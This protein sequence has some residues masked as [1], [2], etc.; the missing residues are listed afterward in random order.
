MRHISLFTRDVLQSINFLI[1]YSFSDLTFEI[2]SKAK[3]F[4]KIQ[5]AITQAFQINHE[6][7]ALNKK[8]LKSSS[9]FHFTGMPQFNCCTN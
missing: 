9:S 6:I 7:S 5:A 1:W 8:L 3:R 2:I 4:F